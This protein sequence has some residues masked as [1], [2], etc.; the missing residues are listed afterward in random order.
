MN[1]EKLILESRW[2]TTVQAASYL[3]CAKSTLE[4]DRVYR[5]LGIPFAKLGRCIRYDQQDLDAYLESRKE[6]HRKEL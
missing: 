5:L 4:K 6:G 3:G 2:L 1:A